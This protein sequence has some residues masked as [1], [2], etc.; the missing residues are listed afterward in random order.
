MAGPWTP[1][2]LGE[3][4]A[5]LPTTTRPLPRPSRF[6]HDGM[7]TGRYALP[8]LTSASHITLLTVWPACARWAA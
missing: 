7:Y 3:A 4:V 1:P 2:V 5:L 6:C 8:S